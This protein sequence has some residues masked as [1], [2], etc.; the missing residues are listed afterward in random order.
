[1]TDAVSNFIDKLSVVNPF[2]AKFVKISLERLNDEEKKSLAHYIAYYD[3][4]FGD[5]MAATSY[6]FICKEMMREELIFKKNR[7]GKYRIHSSAEA[8]E[9]VYSNDEYMQKY[10]IGLG[11]STFIW[12]NHLLIH[13]YFWE[14]LPREKT[15]LY[16]EIGVGHGQNFAEAARCCKFERYLG[17]DISESSLSM[18]EKVVSSL[19]V[20]RQKYELVLGDFLSAQLCT[21]FDAII[22][23]EVLEH[24]ERPDELLKKIHN[25]ATPDAFIYVTTAINSPAIDHI[26][27]FRSTEEV[28][29]LF[30]SCGLRVSSKLVLP[31]AGKAI[32]DAVKEKLPLNVAFV[33]NKI[34]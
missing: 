15:G 11:L 9:L 6:D 3:I 1:M 10:M 24:V 27:L 30:Q 16:L 32:E 2:Q 18:T 31:P 28:V 20:S 14:N 34:G 7:S 13:R 19:G 21:H 17:Y 8:N 23:G 12:P 33:L 5:G 26:H 22:C 25:L 29:Q 4:A